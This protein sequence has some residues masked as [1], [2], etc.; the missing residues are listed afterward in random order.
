MGIDLLNNI[1]FVLVAMTGATVILAKFRH[2]LDR[3]PGE[4]WK[5]FLQRAVAE[6]NKDKE[7]QQTMFG[8]L[9]A[10]IRANLVVLTLTLVFAYS[11]SVPALMLAMAVYLA[12]GF[13]VSHKTANDAKTSG[14]ARLSI[15][16][17]LW[18]RL[19]FAWTWPL[20]LLSKRT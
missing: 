13:F 19:Y 16:D 12:V 9:G 1:A 4:D 17:R 11:V 20:G 15:A 14:H 3:K 18:F 10:T 2:F 7:A 8:S 5:S 6:R